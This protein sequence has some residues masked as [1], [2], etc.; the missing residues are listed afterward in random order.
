MINVKMPVADDRQVGGDHYKAMPVEPW[1]VID[2]WPVDQRVGF[3]RGNAL[4]YLL[5]AGHKGQAITDLEKARHYID[6]LLEV[7]NG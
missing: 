3:Y 5:R 6:K 7:L 2:T 4:K 1:R